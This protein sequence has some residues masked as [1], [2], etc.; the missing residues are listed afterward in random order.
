MVFNEPGKLLFNSKAL[1][2]LT[3][4]MKVPRKTCYI[5]P[6]EKVGGSV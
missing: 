6:I 2:P 1:M 3:N 4:E 5:K